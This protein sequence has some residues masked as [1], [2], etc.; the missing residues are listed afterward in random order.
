MIKQ[1]LREAVPKSV[2]RARY[3]R[4]LSARFNELTAEW[5]EMRSGVSSTIVKQA[6]HNL[7]IF[8]GD[9]EQVVGSLGDQA[10]IMAAMQRARATNHDVAIHIVVNGAH[11]AA[12]ARTLGAEPLDVWND[13]MFL[14]RIVE[15]MAKRKIDTLVTVGADIIDGV[16]G[17]LVPARM[18]CVADV[19]ARMGISATI[20]GSSFNKQPL[21]QLKS[22]FDTAHPDITFCLRDQ[23]S[24][25]RFRAFTRAKP[26]L[27]ADSALLLQTSDPDAEVAGWVAKQRAERRPVMGF[28]LHPMLVKEDPGK[29]AKL[30]RSGVLALS[31]ICRDSDTAWL[32]IP[33]DRRPKVGDLLVLEAIYN[34]LSP[35][36]GDRVALVDP[37][38]RSAADLKAIAGTLD[39]V[40][41][42][43]MHLAIAS[44]GKGVPVLCV[45]YQDKFEGLYAH[46]GL[47]DTMLIDPHSAMD[48]STLEGALRR[49][50][51]DIPTLRS[52]IAAC[53]PEVFERSRRN[54][55]AF[56]T[57]A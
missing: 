8:P 1:L 17:I 11:A 49:L 42:G 43:R 40:V 41:S 6:L 55:A 54:F 21:P 25:E 33:H 29:V 13:P 10:M 52:L 45:A 57:M 26:Q 31:A 38:T 56:D 39:G 46:F 18:I 19:A 51:A 50:I 5:T 37:R 4:W 12:V 32:L 16:Y 14:H 20:L 2:R 34:Q 53:L 48:P 23:P 28:N 7:L 22:L 36:F 30:V 44:L 9:P 27:V 47:P 24:L 3:D 35:E 15:Q